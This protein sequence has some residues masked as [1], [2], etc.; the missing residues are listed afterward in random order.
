MKSSK[1]P[2]SRKGRV[3]VEA[4]QDIVRSYD[5]ATRKA[6]KQSSMLWLILFIALLFVCSWTKLLHK[7]DPI[8]YYICNRRAGV[9][10]TSFSMLASCIGGSATLGVIGL[11]WQVGIPA[12][13]WLGAGVAGLLVLAFFLARKVRG[14]RAK[15]MPEMLEKQLGQ[16]FRSGCAIIILVAYVPIV[17]AQLSA[18]ALIISS[19]GNLDHLAALLG[20]AFFL[21]A[22]TALGGQN[23]VMKS[24]IW[25]FVILMCAIGLILF[26]CLSMPQGRAAL[27]DTPPVLLNQKFPPQKLVYYLLILGGS[28][29]V[30]PMLYGRLLSSRSQATAKKSCIASAGGLFVIAAAITAIGI[31]LHG[32]L[33]PDNFGAD[34]RAED[35][36]GIFVREK[37]PPW[38]SAP[39]L[40]GLLSAIVSSADSCL[41]TAASIVANDLFKKPG[42]GFCRAAMGVLVIAACFL[43][44]QGKGILNLLL[45][46]NDIY[47]CGI[48]PPVFIAIICSGRKM[49]PG[50]MTCALACGGCAGAVASVLH[51]EYLSITAFALSLFISLLAIWA[52]G[53]RS[54]RFS[55]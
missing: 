30:G 32:I 53:L 52:Q 33:P 16:T 19:I 11:A 55:A 29:V 9:T 48:V 46:A 40:L 3:Q 36:L 31:S 26:F 25:Q 13:W 51:N 18:Q 41:F 8:Q 39:I 7:A 12:F 44:L 35:I 27:A 22:Y 28:F 6:T 1:M 5:E 23:A 38:A 47:A 4:M 37:M 24:D 17:A 42:T 43:A 2:V 45:I 15:T 20:G 34:F 49:H 50:I 54:L 10:A 21:Y 14:S